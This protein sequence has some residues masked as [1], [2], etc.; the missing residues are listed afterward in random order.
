MFAMTNRSRLPLPSGHQTSE[1]PGHASCRPR[2]QITGF[3]DPSLHCQ[4]SATGSPFT[5]RYTGFA[6]ATAPQQ[7]RRS[8]NR[9]K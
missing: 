3:G 2:S 1:S 6:Q 4:Y 9:T 8:M 7:T 5:S